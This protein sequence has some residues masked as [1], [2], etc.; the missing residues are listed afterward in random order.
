[1]TERDKR[2]HEKRNQPQPQGNLG[3]KDAEQQVRSEDE[4]ARMGELTREKNK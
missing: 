1:M 3:Q 2:E 4:I